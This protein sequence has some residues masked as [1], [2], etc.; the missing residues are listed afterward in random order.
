[1]RAEH[2]R[3]RESALQKRLQHEARM[4]AF[5]PDASQSSSNTVRGEE[6]IS[7]QPDLEDS[8]AKYSP[9]ISFQEM[10]SFIDVYL[11]CENLDALA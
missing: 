10:M 11:Q 1:M 4:L 3:D 5:T 8:L 2:E 9:T 6:S 7:T